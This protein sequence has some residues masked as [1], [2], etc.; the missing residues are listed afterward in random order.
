MTTDDRRYTDIAARTLGRTWAMLVG[1]ALVGAIDGATYTDTCPADGRELAHVPLGSAEDAQQAVRTAVAAAAEWRDVPLAARSRLLGQAIGILRDNATELGVL[2][3]LDSGNPARAMIE[4]VGMACDWL[5]YARGVAMEVKG[6]TLPAP[7]NRWL[8]TRREPYGVVLRIT[9]YNH[10]ILFAIQKLGAPL[11]MGN[12]LILKVPQQT[13]L[14]P[15]RM[16]ELL[17]D[18]FPPGVLSVMTGSGSGL[19]DALVRHP[20]IKRIS[21]IGGMRTGQ[22][23]QKSAA[24][25]GIKHVSLELGGKNPMIILDDADVETAAQAAVKGMNFTKTAGQSCGSCS[26]LFVHRTLHSTVVARI[27]ELLDEIRI[28]H[29]LDPEAQ[30]GCLVSDRERDRVQAMI[31]HAV[32]EGAELRFGGG[33][34]AHLTEGAYLAP[35]VLDNVTMDMTIGHEEVFGPVL[36]VIPWDDP[37]QMLADVN[38]VPLGLTSSVITRD[39]DKALHLAERLDSGYVWINDCAAHYVGAP[40]SGHRNSGTDS[41]EGIAE[42]YS[43]TQVKTVVVAVD[44]DPFDRAGE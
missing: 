25:T 15:L 37:E 14:A 36:S 17:E 21:L 42:L 33:A 3:G 5:E 32:E 23:I 40:F 6:E 2:D 43:Y 9:A 24:E 16:G 11:L 10:P 20:D 12:T 30:M 22:T 35:T 28:G 38:A 34:P 18:V 44:P 29:P 8:M 31:D 19:G 39:I 13:P 1:G 4:E 26:R 27:G 7:A 41:E